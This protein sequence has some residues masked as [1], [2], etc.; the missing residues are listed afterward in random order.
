[1][2]ERLAAALGPLVGVT[3]FALA[4]WILEHQLRAFHYND[5]MGH[6]SAIPRSGL[7][8]ALALTGASYLCLTGYDFLALREARVR[9]PYPRVGLASFVAYV[10]SHNL[11]LSFLGGTAVR[12]RMY[13]SWGVTP[14]D[15]ARVISFN[16]V[17]FWLGFLSVGGLALTLDPIALPAAWQAW[18]ATS[19]PFGLLFLAALAVWCVAGL[20]GMALRVRGFE[21]RVPG[22]LTTALQILLSSLDW[23]LAGAVLYALLPAAD[24][25]S[26]ATL[27]GVYLLA[28]V[29]GLVS[30]VPA[31]LGV[32]ETV[33]VVLL[34]PWL[35]GDAVLASAVAYR[36]VYYLIPLGAA[37][38]LFAGFEVLQRR[39]VLRTA[40]SLLAQWAPE[41]VPRVMAL[42]TFATGALL[43]VSGATPAAPG[44]MEAIDRVLPLPL[45]EISHFTAS[46]LGVVLVLLARA[47]QQRVDAAYSLTL[48]VLL[49][50][51]VMELAKGLDWEEAS[52]L[53][54]MAI[55]LAPCHRFFY[56]KS[57]LLTQ[58]FSPGWTA[59][60]GMLL[61]GTAY[62]VLL[63]YRQV[64]Y[65]HEL[66]WQ[67]E[68]EGHAPR[69]L[70]ALA[71]AAILLGAYAVAR[72]LRPATRLPDPPSH[73]EIE[74]VATLV[75]DSPCAGAH[76]ALVGD[77]Q[78]LFHPAGTGFLM[79]GVRRRSWIAMGD[80]IGPPEVRRELAW[81]FRELADRHGAL[82]A[83]YEVQTEDL[84][85]YLD[86]GMSLRRLGEEARVPLERFSLE[87][88]ARKGLRNTLRRSE[89]EGCRFELAPRERVAGLMPRLRV[90]SDEWLTNKQTR[91][92]RFSLGFF[93]PDYLQRTPIALVWRGEELVAFANVWASGA[94]SEL[95]IDLM[96]HATAAPVGVMEY[97]FTQLILWGQAQGYQWFSL[98]M[99]PLS[100]FER[101]RLAPLWNRLGA[102][103]FRHGENFYNFKGLRNFK[104]KFDPLWEPRY[105]AAPGGFASALVL[106]D[107]AA[108]ISGGVTGVV[109]R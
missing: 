39:H 45:V 5:V 55:A 33:L 31:G 80:P 7:L 92:K 26:F 12:Y 61:L 42:A 99:A 83:F 4:A 11:G 76:L 78:I 82:T 100:G 108:L 9:L 77:K 64:E 89:R 63:A 104:E 81:Q 28:Q 69:S 79:Y 23:T 21:M 36:I 18:V 102:L 15:L 59:A 105:L 20:R 57:S 22:P 48:V 24:G 37:A 84:P 65:Q 58:P 25:L 87:G 10:F 14:A 85:V 70:R 60:I 16:A 17:T 71:G 40:R 34:S 75:A 74:R 29:V 93:D 13:T 97:L 101:H 43:L 67:F 91:E 46:L 2:K 8:L 47:I 106:A 52:V 27:L 56:R 3:L 19:R 53:V 66:W 51:A 41:L 6:L 32:F 49:V 73:A 30:H 98:G 94:K 50:G 90:I 62:I 35:P 38:G 72:L 96:R 109:A 86:L 95:S 1:M 107:A 88:S 103:L 44:R 68:L 54:G